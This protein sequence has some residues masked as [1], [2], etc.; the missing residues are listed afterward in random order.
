MTSRGGN[1][2]A[3]PSSMDSRGRTTI[4]ASFRA[5]LRVKPG[6]QLIWEAVG[7]GAFPVSV[8]PKPRRKCLRKLKLR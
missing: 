4:P 2:R 5:H 6:D 1:I 7:D 8:A 3:Y